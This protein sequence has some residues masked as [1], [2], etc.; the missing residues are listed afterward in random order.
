VAALLYC[1]AVR[2]EVSTVVA[3]T[4]GRGPQV[5]AAAR[6]QTSDAARSDQP[7]PQAPEQRWQ[8]AYLRALVLGDTTLI[9]AVNLAAVD[10]R[11]GERSES[12]A[13]VPYRLVALLIAAIWMA[14]LAA[15]RGYEARF[16]GIGYEEYKRVF[17]ASF[18]LL[19]TVA[20]LAFAF[21]VP[22]ARGFLLVSLGLGTVLLVSFRY[23]A[24]RVLHR[25]R[26]AGRCRHRVLVVGTQHSVADL[27]AEV[28]REPVAG[29]GV[30][31]ACLAPDPAA[32]ADPVLLDLTVPVVGDVS[33][34][35]AAAASVSA[36]TIAMTAAPGVTGALMRRLAWQ[37]EGTGIDLVVAPA[38]T[39][40]AGPRISIRPVAGLP[41][42]HVD[43]P[44]ITGLR[45]LLKTVAER[46]LA[47]LIG[48]LT[49]PIVL[50]AGLAITLDSR[51]PMFFRQVRVNRH[52]GEFGLLK[53]RSMRAGAA[54]DL[55]QVLD[56]ND[57][58]GVLFKRR[59]DPRVTPVGRW[60]RRWSIDELPQ[61]WNVVMG[62]MALVGPR[63]PLPS[64]V[65][66]YDP[67]VTRRLLV[68]PGLTGLWQV[69]GRSDLSWEETVRLDLYY[70]ENWSLALDIQI[71]LRTLR[72]VVAG[73][74]AY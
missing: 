38:L 44:E 37:L 15:S 43:E 30:V 7:A 4:I 26:L 63:P 73:R 13:G 46:G 3:P 58:D 14:V 25:A 69:S 53:L 41:L 24:R 59:D 12:L 47:L 64:E 57:G 74:G 65:A 22:I 68:K 6:D 33:D 23:V 32:R 62:Q 10:V 5:L 36:D 55:A 28:E 51:G 45:Y 8:R 18:R 67:D 72:A 1:S 56:R 35:A 34:I 71:L 49:L 42:L 19:S 48:V 16:L 31:G 39:N 11:F 27:V 60:L 66:S 52:G 50:A 29:F 40:V 21:R 20:L 2:V 17:G 61:L 54:D 9:L 70:V